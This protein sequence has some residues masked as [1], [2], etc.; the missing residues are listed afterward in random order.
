MF[1]F[2][3]ALIGGVFSAGVVAGVSDREPE[4]PTP[5]PQSK[6]SRGDDAVAGHPMPPAH[7][8]DKPDDDGHPRHDDTDEHDDGG[9]S[10]RGE[11]DDGGHTGHDD[12]D[13]PDDGGHAGHDSGAGDMPLPTN[14]EEIAAFVT[15]VR[16]GDEAHVH[17]VDSP[18]LSEHN[19]V[20]DL[21][22]PSEATHI[23]IAHGSWFSPENW[24]NGEIPGDGAKV[25]IPDG[26]YMEYDQVSDTRLFTLRVDGQ[27][28]F[29]TDADAQMIVDTFVVSPVG[30][31]TIGTQD[32]PVDADV[33]V[34][35]IFANNGAIDVNWDPNLISRGIISHG[36][37]Q[38]HGAMKDSHEKVIDAPLTGDTFVTFADQPEGWEVGDT[39]V[40]AGTH[41]DGHRLDH[42]EMLHNEPED[43]VRVISSIDGNAVHFDDPL[44][45]DHDT[46]RD[47][48]HTSVANY[49]R[50]VSFSTEDPET[51]EISERGHAMFMHSDDV[52]IRYAEF[53]E[54]G[55]TDKSEEAFDVTDFETIEADSNVKGRYGLH[56]HRLGTDNGDDPAIVEGNAVFG[57]P[58]WGFVHHDSNAILDNN[59]AYDTFG[60]GFV[61]ESGNEIGAW[62][63]N[64]SIYSEG[65]SWAV[66]KNAVS[67]DEFLEFDLGKSGDGFWFQGRM[68]SA[69]GNIAASVNTGFVYFHR[70]PVGEGGV[71]EF[72]ASTTPMPE[73]F[74]G[75]DD[76]R[77]DDV[78]IFVFDGNEA[79]AARE[80]LHIVKAN[81]NQGHDVHS[82][83]EDFTA[84]SVRSGA[85]LEYT[86]HYVLKNFDLIAREGEK[87]SEPVSGI[88]FASNTFDVTIVDS[89]IDGFREGINL[90]KNFTSNSKADP[91]ETHDF[92]VVNTTITGPGD[93]YKNYDP[94]ED[95]I[96]DSKPDINTAPLLE[97]DAPLVFEI[98]PS[99]G[100]HHVEITGT[101]TDSLGTTEFPSGTDNFDIDFFEMR[102]ILQTDG[103][104]SDTDDN[105]YFTLDVHFS[106]RL[107]GDIYKQTELVKFAANAPSG[108]FAEENA[109]NKGELTLEELQ[110]M[111]PH[112]AELIMRPA[113]ASI[114]QYTSNDSGDMQHTMQ[115]EPA[116][117]DLITPEEEASDLWN[118]LTEGFPTQG[119]EAPLPEEPDLELVDV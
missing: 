49:T 86:S 87:F 61:A 46:P 59:A 78:P 54:L 14:P 2:L 81:P 41:Y 75:D 76:V 9:H 83:L 108:W 42:G 10:G 23:A 48:L 3:M 64:I 38:I 1:A 99:T 70:G 88:G 21:V 63:D 18:V 94:N 33:N 85:H 26:V 112:T 107:T 44:V 69:E 56:L 36:D 101:K 104:Y 93:L 34:D 51:A 82:V 19:A 68:V 119:E 71:A 109:I 5:L 74:F 110:E 98:G 17:D 53:Y 57:S 31:L 114:D 100:D 116:L 6:M 117:D 39:I 11:P 92:V 79:F 20:L 8:D 40:I 32:D 73:L 7:D 113:T 43:E 45:H 80:G 90:A 97:F 28:D 65:V 95:I 24:H 115:Q 72:D 58:G 91:D 4:S 66:P 27:L 77:P 13:E 35:I 30:T 62:T 84:W 12:T 89:T 47:D 52:D 55:R 37:V 50:N 67:F 25:L 103:F 96:L 15:A 60:A 29:A 111:A 105:K 22:A 16:A 118:A 102:H 106:D